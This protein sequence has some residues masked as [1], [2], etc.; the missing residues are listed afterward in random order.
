MEKH[1]DCTVI[2]SQHHLLWQSNW[3]CPECKALRERDAWRGIADNLAVGLIT[4][5]VIASA[6][7]ETQLAI[8]EY[9]KATNSS[10]Y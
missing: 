10:V 6:N 4:S 9:N 7:E 1:E 5:V 8:Q 2:Q 3:D